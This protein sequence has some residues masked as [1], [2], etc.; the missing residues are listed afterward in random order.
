MEKIQIGETDSCPIC[1]QHR[2]YTYGW[3]YT[4][5]GL[6]EMSICTEHVECRRLLDKINKTREELRFLDMELF[7]K[8]WNIPD[9]F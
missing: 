8:K 3:R 6:L 5:D 9:Y 4:D 7:R 2:K 1:R